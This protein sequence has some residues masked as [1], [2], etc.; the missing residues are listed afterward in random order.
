MWFETYLLLFFFRGMYNALLFESFD[1]RVFVLKS[2]FQ[3]CDQI[4]YF[5]RDCS[6][7]S[8]EYCTLCLFCPTFYLCWFQSFDLYFY[9][10]LEA[11]TFVEINVLDEYIF[12]RVICENCIAVLALSLW[13]QMY[14]I[15]KILLL[16]SPFRSI[17]LVL[18]RSN[19]YDLRSFR[20][21]F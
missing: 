13:R 8:Y 12:I 1:L 20:Q 4:S 16:F 18:I 19:E 11:S 7:L 5:I 6:K 2:N 9:H 17:Y 21:K 10:L 14:I 15:V 3:L